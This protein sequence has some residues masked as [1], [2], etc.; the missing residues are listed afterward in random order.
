[1][2]TSSAVG[3]TAWVWLFQRTSARVAA[4]PEDVLFHWRLIWVLVS[5]GKLSPRTWICCPGVASVA[6]E[7]NSGCSV[8]GGTLAFTSVGAASRGWETVSVN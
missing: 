6:D 5:R 8:R 2:L 3:G 4:V 1:V 7:N